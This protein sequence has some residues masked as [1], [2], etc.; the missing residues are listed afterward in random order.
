MTV[1]EC[2]DLALSEEFT[3]TRQNALGPVFLALRDRFSAGEFKMALRM[4][5]P[6]PL[7]EKSIGE[8]IAD[9]LLR[10]ALH[11][12]QETGEAHELAEW[13]TNYLKHIP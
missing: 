1:H 9:D 8:E 3:G 6:E 7:T 4:A 5:W 12:Y 10:K 13:A 2:L 11:H